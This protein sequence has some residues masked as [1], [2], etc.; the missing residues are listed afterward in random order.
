MLQLQIGNAYYNCSCVRYVPGTPVGHDRDRGLIIGLVVGIVLPI[1]IVIIIIIIVLVVRY[2]RRNKER[3]DSDNYNDTRPGSMDSDQNDVRMIRYAV[4]PN[5]PDAE[6]ENNG[7]AYYN[8]VKFEP[9][10]KY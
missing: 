9:E 1:L 4:M 2:R 7:D 8:E 5:A 3:Q 10:K 6:T